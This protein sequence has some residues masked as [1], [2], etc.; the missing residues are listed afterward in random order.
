MMRQPE[1]PQMDQLVHIYILLSL[2]IG[3]LLAHVCQMC[4][5]TVRVSAQITQQACLLL[6]EC[7]KPDPAQ[8]LTCSLLPNTCTRQS[9]KWASDQ[10]QGGMFHK[11][12]G[13]QLLQ[14]SPGRAMPVEQGEACFFQGRQHVLS[15]Y[16]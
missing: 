15:C 13:M 8:W 4:H 16:A 1:L 7:F 9:K 2:Y 10:I 14:R 6:L 12:R 11:P 5:C 3:C